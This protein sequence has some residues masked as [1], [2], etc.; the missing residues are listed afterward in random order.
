MN[1][2]KRKNAGD[3]GENNKN[4]SNTIKRARV[5]PL[6]KT[7]TTAL[8]NLNLKSERDPAAA[9]A[10]RDALNCNEIGNGSGLY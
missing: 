10:L 5:E 8:K 7:P 6:A 4:G 9:E 2:S 1:S 3:R